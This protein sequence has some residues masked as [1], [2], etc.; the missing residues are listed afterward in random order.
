MIETLALGRSAAPA[1]PRPGHTRSQKL[2]PLSPRER[3]SQSHW[4]SAAR[5]GLEIGVGVGFC[6]LFS[7]WTQSREPLEVAGVND[8]IA[9]RILCA[10][11]RHTQHK[12]LTDKVGT[13]H[14]SNESL[15][16]RTALTCATAGC[17]RQ[18]YGPRAHARRAGGRR[19][20]CRPSA[21]A[22]PCTSCRSSRPRSC[23]TG[24]RPAT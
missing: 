19:S 11:K 16:S 5:H 13:L 21:R 18:G 6:K 2:T 3:S 20:A 7:L 14:A 17:W 10:Q 4:I 1:R 12:H 8:A 15:P 22:C 9:N 23:G 24:G